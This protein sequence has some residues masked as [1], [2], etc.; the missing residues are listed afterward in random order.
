MAVKFTELSPAA[1]LTARVARYDDV[2]ASDLVS[3]PM[4]VTADALEIDG[5]ETSV[6]R[7]FAQA[8]WSGEV[9]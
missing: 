3:D 5:T 2:T 1:G 6:G 9:V 7:S 8:D 4:T